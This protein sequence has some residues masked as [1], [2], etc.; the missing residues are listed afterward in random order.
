MKS[1]QKLRIARGFLLTIL[2]VGLSLISAHSLVGQSPEPQK[3]KTDA[4][5]LKDRLQV[6]EQ[7]VIE[8]KEQLAALEETKKNPKPAIIEAT[9]TTPASTGTAAAKPKPDDVDKTTFQIYGFAMLDAGYDFKTNH[10]DWFDVIR[11]TK[12]PSFAGEF[13]P[14]GKT[15]MGVRQS[16]LGV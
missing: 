8:L 11:P 13:A 4:E 3:P 15:Y 6:L 9:Y 1:N 5:Q 14:N 2:T 12:L 7:T 16:R 10:P